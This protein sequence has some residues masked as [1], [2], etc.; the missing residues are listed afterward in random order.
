MIRLRN[1]IVI[2][3]VFSIVISIVTWYI[4]VLI[5]RFLETWDSRL[6]IVDEANEQIKR[7]LED[8]L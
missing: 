8:T 1:I 4:P 3:V 6:E 5:E 2:L 7:Y